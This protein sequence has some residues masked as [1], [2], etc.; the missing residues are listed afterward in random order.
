MDESGPE[1]EAKLGGGG[2]DGKRY[3]A[4]AMKCDVFNFQDT[5][6]VDIDACLLFTLANRALYQGFT[7]FHMS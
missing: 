4:A 6:E 3:T 1:K 7:G 5:F 2:G